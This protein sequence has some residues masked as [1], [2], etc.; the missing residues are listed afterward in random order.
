MGAAL[1]VFM[2]GERS[3]KDGDLLMNKEMGSGRQHMIFREGTKETWG[4]THGSSAPAC[5]WQKDW[6]GAPSRSVGQP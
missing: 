3:Q 5:K 2:G 6:T 1:D 4:A